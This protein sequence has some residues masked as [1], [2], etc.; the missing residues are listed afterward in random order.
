MQKAEEQNVQIAL[1]I[2]SSINASDLDNIE[3][4]AHYAL[5]RKDGVITFH[6]RLQYT[7]EEALKILAGI[8]DSNKYNYYLSGV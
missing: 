2:K 6:P 7:V 1:G 3:A 8:P 4:W 5:I